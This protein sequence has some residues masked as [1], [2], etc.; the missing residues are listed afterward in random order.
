MAARGVLALLL[1]VLAVSGAVAQNDTTAEYPTIAAAAEAANLTGLAQLAQGS[2]L[3]SALTNPDWQGIVLAP[4]NAAIEEL[5]A[6]LP[7]G[8]SLSQQEIDSLLSYHV[9]PGNASFPSLEFEG[10]SYLETLLSG[11]VPASEV[12]GS[13]SFVPT[14][15]DGVD[16]L[17]VGG[18]APGAL[19]DPSDN[20]TAAQAR[21]YVIDTVLIPA[22]TIGNNTIPLTVAAAANA[23]G[24][25]TTLLTAVEADSEIAALLTDPTAA[26]TIFA[27][28][29][30]AFAAFLEASN[31]TAAD[32][33]SL[34]GSETVNKILKTHVLDTKP[35]TSTEVLE[36]QPASAPTLAEDTELT[37]TYEGETVKVAGPGND[38]PANVVAVDVLAGLSVI[39]VID[40]V[41]L[42][43][44]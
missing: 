2:V 43:A 10:R 22:A 27:P 9:I 37:F 21:I 16:G 3:E 40:K 1:A 13:V 26:Y 41:L 6:S 20:V 31:L 39:H 25:F 42:P 15:V 38:E 34:L 7:A 12:T 14:T 35:Y 36:S 8:A 29:D 4:T 32:L 30:E 28:T 5:V 23:T 17:Y 18:R 19:L 33:P 11:Q 24:N 44:A